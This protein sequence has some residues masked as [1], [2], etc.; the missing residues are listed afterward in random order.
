MSVFGSVAHVAASGGDDRSAILTAIAQLQS[1][2]TELKTLVLSGDIQIS[3]TIAISGSPG[4]MIEGAGGASV[5]QN[6]AAAATF[7]FTGCSAGGVRGI[8]FVAATADDDAVEVSGSTDLVFERLAFDGYTGPGVSFSGTC[9]GSRCE[10]TEHDAG[11]IIELVKELF[12]E[13]RSS[14]NRTVYSYDATAQAAGASAYTNA[15]AWYWFANDG[16]Y[17]YSRVDG[18]QIADG[19]VY[20]GRDSGPVMMDIEVWDPLDEQE[21]MLANLRIAASMWKAGSARPRGFYRLLPYSDYYNP[22]YL[23]RAID[24]SDAAELATRESRLRRNMRLD[25]RTYA[26][27]GHDVD[28]LFPKCYILFNN[29]V[30]LSEGKWFAT[31][32]VMEALR[33]ARP[34]Q[35]VVPVVWWWA[36]S[37]GQALSEA[38]WIS[39]L[40][41]MAA[42][43]GI[44][45]L[46]VYSGGTAPSAYTWTDAISELI[47]GTGN[48]V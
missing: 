27:I 34:G 28:F 24:S 30:G 13:T 1:S 2:G 44:A 6:L 21:E 25:D 32:S 40:Q 18:A 37:S 33:L 29:D 46:A 17:D 19:I 20:A 41:Y 12:A 5:T 47:N 8:T 22:V 48:F 35:S 23:K 16:S 36:G 43:P 31:W 15:S 9:T 11:P 42:L 14:Y 39:Y 10:V 38:R 45:G 7:T 4:V 3:G 26:A